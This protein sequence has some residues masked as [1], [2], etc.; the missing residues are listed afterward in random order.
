MIQSNVDNSQITQVTIQQCNPYNYRL[1]DKGQSVDRWL[2]DKAQHASP[3]PTLYSSGF[4]D[5]EVNFSH[6]IILS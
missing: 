6:K 5:S 3:E 2:I 4:Q 1:A